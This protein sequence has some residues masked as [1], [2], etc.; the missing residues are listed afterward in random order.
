[1]TQPNKPLR[2]GNVPTATGISHQKPSSTRKSASIIVGSHFKLGK[3]LGKGN[4]GEVRYGKN[5]K[6]NEDVAIKTVYFK[7]RWYFYPLSR[8]SCVMP[9]SVSCN[10]VSHKRIISR[11]LYR[12]LIRNRIF[13]QQ[14]PVNTK[15][16]QLYLEYQMYKVMGATSKYNNIM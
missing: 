16:P 1:M 11:N 13:S 8:L 6:N 7:H 5:M 3:R 4:F 10:F 9:F 2:T 14:E 12:V 15:I